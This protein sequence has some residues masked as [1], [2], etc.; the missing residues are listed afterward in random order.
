MTPKIST[1]RILPKSTLTKA[2]QNLGNHSTSLRCLAAVAALKEAGRHRKK[3]KEKIEIKEVLKTMEEEMLKTE[4]TGEKFEVKP[5]KLFRLN[6]SNLKTTTSIAVAGVQVHKYESVQTIPVRV[7]GKGVYNTSILTAEIV[8][9][10]LRKE[11]GE[12]ETRLKQADSVLSSTLNSG[13]G[14]VRGKQRSDNTQVVN[15]QNG[16]DSSLRSTN[17]RID[18]VSQ[19]MLRAENKLSTLPGWAAGSYCILAGA[20]APYCPPGFTVINPKINALEVYSCENPRYLIPKTFGRSFIKVHNRC[21]SNQ[22]D[23]NL[24]FCCK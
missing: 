2:V 12:L 1:L 21:R 11:L 9:G 4:W 7:A 18:T 20:T 22:V 8:Q 14:E 3:I 19:K 10:R 24:S 23:L 16:L 6:L 15:R 17:G 13:L 5:M